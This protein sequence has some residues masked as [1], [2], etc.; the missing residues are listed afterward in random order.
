[1]EEPQ[2]PHSQWGVQQWGSEM[3]GGDKIAETGGVARSQK[4][5]KYKEGK[6]DLKYPVK[7]LDL[8]P[9]ALERH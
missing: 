3:G 4:D 6:K 2:G 9:E 8:C 7:H 5:L 1:M